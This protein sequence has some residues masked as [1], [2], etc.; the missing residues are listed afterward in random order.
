[1]HDASTLA[2]GS[3][4][5][6]GGV[7]T[8]GP[9]SLADQARAC[10]PGEPLT[11]AG[12]GAAQVC[13]PPLPAGSDAKLCVET[14]GAEPCPSASPYV[15]QRVLYNGF[16][17]TRV[18][19]ACTCGAPACNGTFRLFDGNGCTDGGGE[20]LQGSCFHP[21]SPPDYATY[22]PEVACTPAGGVPEGGATGTSPTTFCCTP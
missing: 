9:V 16:A 13:A 6:S 5:A 10:A 17:D 8:G 7:P 3:C 4:T 15:V 20:L 12:C 18:C 1:M 19:T 11:S 22:T 2:S 14:T 21:P